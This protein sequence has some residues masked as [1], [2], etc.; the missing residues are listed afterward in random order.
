M[1]MMKGREGRVELLVVKW[2]VCLWNLEVEG[3]EGGRDDHGDRGR[4]RKKLQLRKESSG[5]EG[6]KS[7]RDDN[8]EGKRGRERLG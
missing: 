6:N 8:G 4:D 1:V 7:G 3:R 5:K 2:I